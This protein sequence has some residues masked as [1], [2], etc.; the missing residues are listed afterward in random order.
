MS[1]RTP[2]F[3]S[4][5]AGTLLTLGIGG[6]SAQQSSS[7]LGKGALAQ[8]WTATVKVMTLMESGG[9]SQPLSAKQEQSLYAAIEARDAENYGAC[10]EKIKDLPSVYQ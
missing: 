2:L 7:D 6:A 10:V 8:C 5:V 1:H 4:L 9:L 3:M